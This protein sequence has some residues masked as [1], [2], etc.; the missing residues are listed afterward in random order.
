MSNT[1]N[2]ERL[3]KALARAGVASRRACEE[4]IAAGR[5]KVNGKI[6]TELGTKIDPSRDRVLVDEHP[7]A[8][9]PS[10]TPRKIYIALNKPEGYLSTVSDPQGRPTIMDLINI[11]ERLYPV[12]RLD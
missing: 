5:V 3:Q 2:E 12:G 7:I 1:N 6:V 9:K 4:L 8:V 10:D 11:D